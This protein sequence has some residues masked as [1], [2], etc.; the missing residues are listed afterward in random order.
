[1]QL[2]HRPSTSYIGPGQIQTDITGHMR[3]ILIDWLVEVAE[4]YKLM[5]ETLYTTVHKLAHSVFFKLICCVR[6][7]LL[8]GA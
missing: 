4:E 1:M 6:S 3:A 8:I 2:K 5:Q 7:I